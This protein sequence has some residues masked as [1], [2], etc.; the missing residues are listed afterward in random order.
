MRPTIFSLIIIT[1]WLALASDICRTKSTVYK[2][3]FGQN[4]RRPD[5]G[6]LEQSGLCPDIRAVLFRLCVKLMQNL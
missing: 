5:E 2:K 6:Q 3:M 4:Y 1:L